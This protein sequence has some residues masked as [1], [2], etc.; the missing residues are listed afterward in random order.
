MYDSYCA[1][2]RDSPASSTTIGPLVSHWLSPPPANVPLVSVTE[3]LSAT[4]IWCSGKRTTPPERAVI[5]P[6]NPAVPGAA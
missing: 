2:M 3:A 4:L 6:R 1:S 5:A